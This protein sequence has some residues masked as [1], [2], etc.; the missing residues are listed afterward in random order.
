M[1]QPGPCMTLST[2]WPCRTKCGHAHNCCSA[3]VHTAGA[4][5][6]GQHAVHPGMQGNATS[7]YSL[8]TQSRLGAQFWMSCYC[9]ILR[10]LQASWSCCKFKYHLWSG[11]PMALASMLLRNQAATLHDM[12][13]NAVLASLLEHSPCTAAHHRMCM[14]PAPETCC[15]QSSR[16]MLL[17]WRR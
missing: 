10:L 16:G 4:C 12:S 5:C 8:C 6:A 14:C 17:R 3:Q 2:H 9:P 13:C 1:K 11:C 7:T 15:A